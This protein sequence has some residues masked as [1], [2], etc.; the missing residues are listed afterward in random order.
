MRVEYGSVEKD[1]SPDLDV[2]WLDDGWVAL[3]RKWIGDAEQSGVAEPNAMVLA[4]VGDRPS[5]LSAS[6]GHG[7]D[8]IQLPDSSIRSRMRTWK[9]CTSSRAMGVVTPRAVA[10]SR[11][12]TWNRSSAATTRPREAS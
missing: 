11:P 9:T 7:R 2:D 12:R 8:V 6:P 1:G 4:T 10:A 3:L 5:R